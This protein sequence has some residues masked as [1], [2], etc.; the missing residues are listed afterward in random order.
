MLGHILLPGLLFILVVLALLA[1]AM[2]RLCFQLGSRLVRFCCARGR[3]PAYAYC[4]YR[5]M[6]ANKPKEK[7]TAPTLLLILVFLGLVVFGGIQAQGRSSERESR[8]SL[9]T[10][11]MA[12]QEPV[13]MNP[14][15]NPSWEAVGRGKTREDAKQDALDRVYKDLLVHFR[16]QMP[17]VQ[18][19]PTLKY[20]EDHFLKDEHAQDVE[21]VVRSVGVEHKVVV[22]VELTSADLKKIVQEDR[23]FRAEQRMIFLA[24]VLG[25]LVLFLTCAAVAIRLDESGKGYYRAWLRL[26]AAGIT[27]AAGAGLFWLS[28]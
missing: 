3:R 10:Q 24:K 15:P 6:P 21:K 4:E 17:Q 8:T 7:S 20:M 5:P 25:I 12:V 26:G 13:K 23:H 14:G 2:C 27:A 28:R 18:W 11:K 16:D 1:Y 9:P 22:R 19:M